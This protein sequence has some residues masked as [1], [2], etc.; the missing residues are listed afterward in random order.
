[1][2]VDEWWAE[3][4]K[5]NRATFLAPASFLFLDAREAESVI[6]VGAE[7]I[8]PGMPAYPKVDTFLYTFICKYTNTQIQ[9][10]LDS[11]FVKSTLSLIEN[12]WTSSLPFFWWFE[13]RN[14]LVFVYFLSN[15]LSSFPMGNRIIAECPWDARSTYSRRGR[16]IVQ[17]FLDTFM[18]WR[19]SILF[20]YYILPDLLTLKRTRHKTKLTG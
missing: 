15:M 6:S 10:A 20:A 4:S 9:V 5:S 2:I 1:M 19:T 17:I 8:T 3:K 16:H 13:G 12:N 7:L 18:M 11:C 14:L